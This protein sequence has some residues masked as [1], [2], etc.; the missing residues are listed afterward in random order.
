M[1]ACME[2]TM[3]LV[4][5]RVPSFCP[6]GLAELGTVHVSGL[7]TH[8]RLKLCAFQTLSGLFEPG[9]LLLQSL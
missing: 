3:E 6:C 5:L 8:P 7:W 1:F 4:S 9:V 2:E